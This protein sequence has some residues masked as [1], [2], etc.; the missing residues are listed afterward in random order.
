MYSAAKGQAHEDGRIGQN[1][2]RSN[3]PVSFH[4]YK[5]AAMFLFA[6]HQK[7]LDGAHPFGGNVLGKLSELAPLVVDNLLQGIALV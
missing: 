4:G 6:Q 3:T 1:F 7:P 5:P 2:Q